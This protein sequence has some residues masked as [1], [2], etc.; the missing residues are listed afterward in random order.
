MADSVILRLIIAQWNI[1]VLTQPAML[2]EDM[3]KE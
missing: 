2:K 1:Y 3:L